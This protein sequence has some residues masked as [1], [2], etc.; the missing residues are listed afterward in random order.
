MSK[1]DGLISAKSKQN[2]KNGDKTSGTAV[3]GQKNGKSRAPGKRSDPDFTQITAYIRKET[4]ENVMRKIYK[5]QELSE[6][7]EELLTEWMK[8]AN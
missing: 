7:L 4:H 2:S 8:K 6:L 5:R 1:F 3:S